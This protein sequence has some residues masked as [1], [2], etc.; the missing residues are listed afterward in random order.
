MQHERPKPA[1]LLRARV[2]CPHCWEQFSPEE[3]L[4]VAAHPDLLGDPQIGSDHAQRF[5]PTRFTVDGRAIDAR[6]SVCQ[7]LACP[8]CHLSVPRALL[9][10]G[11]LFVSSLG[12]PSC[13]KSYFLASMIW[14]LR[15]TLPTDFALS[16]SDADPASNRMLN[17]Y[18]QLQFFNPDREALVR[19]RKTEEQGDLYDSVRYGDHVVAYPRPF[20]FGLRPLKTHPNHDRMAQVAR[21]LCLYDNAGESFEPGKDTT[22]NPVTRHLARSQALWFLFDPT[23]DPRFR[24]AC[25]G[26]SNDPQFTNLAVT[27][28]Q[29]IV[30]HEVADRVRKLTGLPQT[31]RHARPLM[32]IVTKYDAWHRLFGPERLDPP[33]VRGSGSFCALDLEQIERVSA[34]LRA[35]LVRYSPDVVSAAEA[36]CEHVTYLPSSATGC[37]P[38]FDPKSG[39]VGLRPGKM[40]PMWAEV[41]L[42][43]TMCRWCR[44]LVPW[45]N[46]ARRSPISAN[47]ANQNGE[48][49]TPTR[50][51]TLRGAA[52]DLEGG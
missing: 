19:L 10:M 15:Q 28:R 17:D 23:Q 9:E 43:L 32:V 5:L 33:W 26:I 20:L 52:S 42:L 37:A 12:T 21:I 50:P 7:D 3:S 38:E 48:A 14:Q 8:K 41:P 18:E 11:P 51:E 25:R 29:D 6:G 47:G 44:G 35:L 30:L 45:L 4:W 39:Q 1:T 31:A 13:G 36:F 22:L 34:Q 24:D 2:P 46:Q 27:R 40:R 16:L 49:Q